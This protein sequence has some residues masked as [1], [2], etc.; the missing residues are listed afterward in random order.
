MTINKYSGTEVSPSDNLVISKRHVEEESLPLCRDAIG[1]YS[2][3]SQ[4]S[5]EEIRITR[6]ENEN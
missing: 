5:S 6:K 3:P 4:V 2:S 1:V